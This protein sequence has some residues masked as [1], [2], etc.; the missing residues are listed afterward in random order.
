MYSDILYKLYKCPNR[1][2]R[3]IIVSLIKKHERGEFRSETLRHIFADYHGIK[4]GMYSYGCFDVSGVPEGTAIGR[5][6]SFAKGFAI[7]NANHP[8]GCLSLH[9]FFYNPKLGIVNDLKIIR[10]HLEIGNDVWVGRNALILYRVK[11][12]GNGAVIG[13]GAVVTKDVPPYAVVAGNPA[14]IL[15]YRFSESLINAAEESRWWEYSIEELKGQIGSFTVSID[16]NNLKSII[17]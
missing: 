16:E 8:L 14:T 3:A 13:A 11:R 12:I 2:L 4:V 5:Y 6:C 10:G 7:L 15:K 1:Q 17:N 9:P